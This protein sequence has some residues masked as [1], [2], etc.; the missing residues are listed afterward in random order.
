LLGHPIHPLVEEGIHTT[1]LSLHAL[2]K[3]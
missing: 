3:N 2:V 1:H